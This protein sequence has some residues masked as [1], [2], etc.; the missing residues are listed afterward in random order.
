MI[1]KICIVSSAIKM[2]GVERASVNIANTIAGQGIDVLFISLFR[3]EHFFRLHPKVQFHE[4]NDF[5][6]TKLCLFK[7]IYWLRKIIK[8]NNP[9]TILVLNYFYGAIVQIAVR[10]LEVPVFISDRHS[11]FYK[12]KTHIKL[13]SDIVFSFFPPRGI[14]AQTQIAAVYK[15]SFFK[16]RTKI[17]V[18]PNALRDVELFSK[19]KKQKQILAVGRLGDHLKGFDQLI[20]AFALLKNQD[21]DLIIAGDEENGDYLKRQAAVLGVL[22]RIQFL[23]RVKE[24]DKIYA[25][26]SIFVIPSRSEGF[27]NA[28]CEAMA[29]GLPCISFDFV[30]GPRDIITDGYDGL[31]VENG[32]VKKL[33]EKIDFLIENEIERKRIGKNAMQIRERLKKE[34][35]VKEYLDFILS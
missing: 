28:L 6:V 21:W 23:G 20:E 5:N 25:Q 26:A 16:K 3:Q 35:I 1:G 10:G 31:L 7:S 8:Q 32:N 4:P 14:I 9:V 12:W 18:I 2:G 33:A 17:K 27:P 22:S 15:A 13:F 34:K 19:I 24:I 11:P 30:A 29:A